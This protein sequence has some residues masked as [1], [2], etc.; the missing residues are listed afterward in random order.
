VNTL[1]SRIQSL[2]EIG[3][4]LTA[5]TNL[6]RLLDLIVLKARQFTSADAGSLYLVRESKL[7][8]EVAQNDTLARKRTGEGAFKPFSLPLDTASIAGYVAVTGEALNLPDVYRLR[9]KDK[10]S[11]NRDFDTRTGYRT[12]SMLVVPMRDHENQVIGVLQ[13]INS[14][15][16]GKAVPF[17]EES[18]PLVLSLASQAAVAIRNA[19]LIHDIQ[20]IFRALVEYS[21]SAIDA[22]S[23]HTAGHSR[24]VALYALKLAR[25]ISASKTGPYAAVS[26]S[27]E[28]LE[29]LEYAAWL[30][31][32][33]KIG[34]RE[35]VLEKRGRL[36]DDRLAL[37][38][39]RMRLARLMMETQDGLSAEE[40]GRRERLL[41]DGQRLV[42]EVNTAGFLPDE[43]LAALNELASERVRGEDGAEVPLLDEFELENLS[44]RRGNLTLSEYREIQSHVRHTLEIL[45]HIPFTRGLRNIPTFAACHHEMLNG[46]GYPAHLT[47]PD[48][49]LQARILAVVDIFDAL[50]A[51]DRPY[52]AAVPLDKTLQILEDEAKLGRLD[53]DLVELFIRGKLYSGILSGP[54]KT[55]P[56][57]DKEGSDGRLPAG[58]RTKNSRGNR[59]RR[60]RQPGG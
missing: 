2:N 59:A 22:R 45:N 44:V 3:I 10:I 18:V 13:L 60:V 1:R 57:G 30:H 23:P 37:V 12:R 9:K 33:G 39:A 17:P 51:R 5:E 8:F 58:G 24:R 42:A 11:F 32:I 55:V 48:I 40:K 27:E 26:F 34:V 43:K 15:E 35:H 31:D 56:I 50:T 41:E 54:E 29:E 38:T 25:A 28:E 47:A 16:R 6:G 46:T 4:A 53:K 20:R 14:L 36:T 7:F 19:S 52:K 21:A 49:P